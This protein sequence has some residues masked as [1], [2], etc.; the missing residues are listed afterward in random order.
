[1][2]TNKEM[3]VKKINTIITFIESN[4]SETSKPDKKNKKGRNTGMLLICSGKFSFIYVFM[5]KA[6]ISRSTVEAFFEQ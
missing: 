3:I 5:V 4:C 2:K 6:L 1:M